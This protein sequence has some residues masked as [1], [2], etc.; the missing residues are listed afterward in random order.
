M[1]RG[2]ATAWAIACGVI[3]WK[4]ILATGTCGR[5]S[6][7]R[8]QA[9]ASPSRSSSVA[10]SSSPASFRSC[11]SLATCGFLSLGTM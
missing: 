8:C 1:S 2:F 11:F 9:I 7:I 4:T 6:S 10:S 3:S 5:S